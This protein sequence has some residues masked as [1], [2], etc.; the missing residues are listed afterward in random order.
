MPESFGLVLRL[1]KRAATSQA[2]RREEGTT[3]RDWP[4]ASLA[5]LAESQIAGDFLNV[6][7]PPKN[8]SS[9]LPTNILR[10]STCSG[11]CF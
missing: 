6:G 10:I 7:R 8:Y 9:S 5:D 1:V 3:L 11:D 4:I 2:S